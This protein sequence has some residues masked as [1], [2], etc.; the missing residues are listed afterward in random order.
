MLRGSVVADTTIP[1]QPQGAEQSER[2]VH[3]DT[4]EDIA[5]PMGQQHPPPH[6]RGSHASLR[7]QHMH[8]LNKRPKMGINGR[9][10]SPAPSE[11]RQARPAYDVRQHEAKNTRAMVARS[12]FGVTPGHGGFAVCS[13]KCSASIIRTFSMRRANTLFIRKVTRSF[14]IRNSRS[15]EHSQPCMFSADRSMTNTE[16]LS[17]PGH[18]IGSPS[19]LSWCISSAAPVPC[20]L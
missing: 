10:G 13:S 4:T 2:A 7:N 1:F 17:A 20:V 18:C 12:V 3:S 14:S 11:R 6:T 9:A 16:C 19:L 5:H 15:L 8:H